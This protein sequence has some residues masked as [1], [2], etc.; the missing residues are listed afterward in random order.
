MLT[1]VST[2]SQ[3]GFEVY[4]KRFLDSFAKFWP[5]ADQVCL[6]FFTEGYP[7]F[8]H[9]NGVI[10]KRWQ[11]DLNEAAPWLSEF[12]YRN[13]GNPRAIGRGGWKH[14]AIRFAHKV[15]A[16]VAADQICDS[17]HLL[18]LDADIVTHSCVD[19]QAIASWL[20]GELWLSW[21]DRDPKVISHPEC[22]FLLFNRQS[23][24]HGV[25]LKTLLEFYVNDIVLKLSETHDSYVF[26]HLVN[27]L[28]LPVRNLSGPGFT[29][30]HPLINSPL[31]H[32]FDHLKGSRKMTG[33]SYKSDLVVERH[34]GYWRGLKI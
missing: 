21:L 15:A 6:I 22:G 3:E 33:H 8:V 29:T 4:G 17:D 31:G 18:W 5:G 9:E 25:A 20:P 32:W 28:G 14:D 23:P 19:E 10:T 2:A 27:L 34:E 26:R 24:H 13:R 7:I 1:V 30:M 16:I 12:K 11:Y